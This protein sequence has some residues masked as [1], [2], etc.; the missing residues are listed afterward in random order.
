MFCIVIIT[1]KCNCYHINIIWRLVLALCAPWSDYIYISVFLA[2]RTYRH[3]SGIPNQ[4]KS[5]SLLT[6]PLLNKIVEMLLFTTPKIIAYSKPFL[7]FRLCFTN[8]D[9]MLQL[10]ATCPIQ[11]PAAPLGAPVIWEA[12]LAL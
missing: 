4:L 1:L 3:L 5:S 8:G 11:R 2:D 6:L 7:D 10:G 12:L 9:W